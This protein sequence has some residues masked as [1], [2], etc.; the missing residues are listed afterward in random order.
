[1]NSKKKISL[2]S[3]AR[4]SLEN[5]SRQSLLQQKYQR[6]NM[7]VSLVGIML[8]L[9]PMLVALIYWESSY[10][11]TFYPDGVEDWI[12]IIV[13]LGI[14][15]AVMVTLMMLGLLLS[16]WIVTTYFLLKKRITKM[17]AKALLTVG[18]FPESWFD[19]TFD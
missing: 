12:T 13:I 5:G 15:I 3:W 6:L 14:G 8:F 7:A 1:M 16:W 17:E 19:T 2:K 4:Q 11:I 10:D 18:K 9:L